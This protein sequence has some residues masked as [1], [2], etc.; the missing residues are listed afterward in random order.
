MA[1]YL[2][3]GDRNRVTAAHDPGE[4]PLVKQS[5]SAECDINKIMEKY[6]LGGEIQHVNKAQG[7]YGDFSSGQEFTQAYTAIA[8]AE[9]GFA[10]LPAHIRDL[11]GNNAETFLYKM[12][13][14]EFREDLVK[15]GVFDEEAGVLNKPLK[16]AAILDQEPQGG[17]L[18]ASRSTP[19]SPAQ[20]PDTE[21]LD[22]PDSPVQGGE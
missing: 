10:E 1:K 20:P 17:S 9:A 6:R 22:E 11:F 13:E 16:S 7:H 21:K 18:E 8:E 15:A 14:D 19:G 4:V 2:A 5:M 12:E 3:R